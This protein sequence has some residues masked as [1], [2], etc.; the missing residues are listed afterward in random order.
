MRPT[1]SF[2]ATNVGSGYIWFVDI[3]PGLI[4]LREGLMALAGRPVNIQASRE[5]VIQLRGDLLG[6]P[7]LTLLEKTEGE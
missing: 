7:Y 2:T 5:L 6:Q 1:S 3:A 4:P